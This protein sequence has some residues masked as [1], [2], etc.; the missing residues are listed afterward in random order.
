LQISLVISNAALFVYNEH[1]SLSFIDQLPSFL[2]CS[3]LD[4]GLIKL[5]LTHNVRHLKTKIIVNFD[6]LPVTP[7]TPPA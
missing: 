4:V 2:N 5:N 7:V 3:V 1:I 6:E